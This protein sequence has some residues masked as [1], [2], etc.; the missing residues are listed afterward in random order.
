VTD[1]PGRRTWRAGASHCWPPSDARTGLSRAFMGGVA[2]RIVRSA[3]CP[4]LTVR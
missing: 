1:G 4:V 3:A 2:E